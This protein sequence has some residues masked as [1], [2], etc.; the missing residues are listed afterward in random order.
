MTGGRGPLGSRSN[1]IGPPAPEEVPG[2]RPPITGSVPGEGRIARGSRLASEAFV[3]IRDDRGLLALALAAVLLDV[4]IA[5]ALLGGASAL[6]GPGHRHV[7]LLGA[8]LIGFYPITVVGTFINV[9]LQW[10]V[11]RRWAGQPAS[12]KE[13][14]RLAWSRRRV[15]LA[16][17][18]VA[19]TIGG[20]VSVLERINHFAWVERLLAVMLS[21]AWSVATFFVIPALAVDGVGPREALR[22]SVRTVRA[23]WA[24]GATGAVAIGGATGLFM[25][26]GVLIGFAGYQAVASEPVAG[27][28]LLAIGIALALPVAVY[29]NATSAVF[30]V[31]VYRYAQGS[32]FYGPF[33]EADLANPFVGGKK[34]SGRIRGWLGRLKARGGSRA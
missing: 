21:V 19:A 25:L 24:E 9:A 7:Y 18:A 13:G 4:I 2:Y 16:W 30:T 3:V 8:M 33:A 10:T 1:Y 23:R 11:A 12:V 26:P 27:I 28:M 20:V 6:A 31:A 29:S 22:R 32:S 5:G 15:I 14:V 17:S 34:G